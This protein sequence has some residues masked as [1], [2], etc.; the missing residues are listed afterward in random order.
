MQ[1]KEFATQT[2]L[3]AATLRYYEQEGLLHP[4]AERHWRA[5]GANQGIRAAAAFGR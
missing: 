4:S 1:T 5:A 2:G 3:S